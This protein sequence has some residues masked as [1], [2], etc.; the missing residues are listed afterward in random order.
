MYHSLF[1]GYAWTFSSVIANIIKPMGYS[2]MQIGIHDLNFFLIKFWNQNF[3][4]GLLM[5]TAGT[6]GGLGA[7][8]YLEL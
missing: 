1:V 4:I 8:V 7:S 6:L 2:V 5:N 3:V